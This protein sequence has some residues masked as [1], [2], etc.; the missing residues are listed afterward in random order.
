MM[1]Q[2]RV[3]APAGMKAILPQIHHGFRWCGALMDSGHSRKE[4]TG[5]AD[6]EPVPAMEGIP[7]RVAG[8]DCRRADRSWGVQLRLWIQR[9]P[10]EQTKEC[11]E[12]NSHMTIECTGSVRTLDVN[13]GIDEE[14]WC[15]TE[16][17]LSEKVA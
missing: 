15:Q 17:S 13:D 9:L 6:K 5:A 16:A 11:P 3:S 4:L 2:K 1:R 10:N 8:M 12:A 14:R 7:D